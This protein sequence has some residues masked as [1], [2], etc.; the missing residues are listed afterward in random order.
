MQSE[1]YMDMLVV[2]AKL[3]RNALLFSEN[4]RNVLAKL[5]MLVQVESGVVMFGAENQVEK[6]LRVGR[7]RDLPS[8]YSTLSGLLMSFV[9]TTPPIAIGG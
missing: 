5:V 7:H 3:I 2:P 1:Q 4:A 6:Y 9:N 8:I